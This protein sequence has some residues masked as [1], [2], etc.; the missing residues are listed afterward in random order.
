M[1]YD[2]PADHLTEQQQRIEQLEASFLSLSE[3]VTALEGIL[4]EIAEVI[5]PENELEDLDSS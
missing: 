3:Q 5:L 1:P 2:N 4:N